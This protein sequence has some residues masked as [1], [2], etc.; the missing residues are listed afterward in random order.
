MI[1][2]SFKKI[3]L[4]KSVLSEGIVTFTGAEDFKPIC[5]EI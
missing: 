2:D 4:F 5:S 3:F 1:T